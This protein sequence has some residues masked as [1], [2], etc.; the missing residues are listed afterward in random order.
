MASA[1]DPGAVVER[2]AAG[3]AGTGGDAVDVAAVEQADRDGGHQRGGDR[4]A[5]DPAQRA[6]VTFAG[7]IGGNRHD[8]GFCRNHV[9]QIRVG[10]HQRIIGGRAGGIALQPDGE[11]V[12]VVKFGI[13][14]ADY[15]SERLLVHHGLCPVH[16]LPLEEPDAADPLIPYPDF[17]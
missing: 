11:G 7:I 17:A 13:A 6:A 14:R 1:C 9:R 10:R 16:F 8:D 5:A 4:A 3:F 15:P 2:D 12:P